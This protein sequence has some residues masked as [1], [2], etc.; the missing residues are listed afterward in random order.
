M[1]NRRNNKRNK[2]K[3]PITINQHQ[4]PPLDLLYHW[5]KEGDMKP[6]SLMR[7]LK[8]CHLINEPFKWRDDR[9]PEVM[10]LMLCSHDDVPLRSMCWMV[11]NGADLR[12]KDEAG[13]NAMHL[14]AIGKCCDNFDVL[15]A[16]EHGEW[17]LN[18][19]NNY[20]DTPMDIVRQNAEEE[21][22]EGIPVAEAI[23]VTEA[24]RI[25]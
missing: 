19:R 10:F 12:A 11:N 2:G 15:L 4:P 7:E 24:Q 22:A 25:N 14:A 18:E 16:T 5:L 6:L 13:M 9:P 3:K 21:E 20:G 17:M 8:W 1:P 23:P